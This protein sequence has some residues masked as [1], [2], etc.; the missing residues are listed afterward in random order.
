[1]PAPDLTEV[2]T[3]DLVAELRDRNEEDSVAE[4]CADL[5][6]KDE[7]ERRELWVQDPAA[8][9]L[10]EAD[11]DQFAEEMDV[12]DIPNVDMADVDR[13]A[14]LIAERQTD[15]A[16]DL[17][18]KMAPATMHPSTLQRLVAD[19]AAESLKLVLA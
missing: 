14:E 1:M 19:R 10:S 4:H 17:L 8:V 7:C 16:L 6:L 2:S 18:R 5:D 12:R 15:D 9:L 11:D 13:L 3:A